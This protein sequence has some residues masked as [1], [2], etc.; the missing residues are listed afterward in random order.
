MSVIALINHEPAGEDEEGDPLRTPWLRVTAPIVVLLAVFA[1]L[2][3]TGAPPAQAEGGTQATA[4]FPVANVTPGPQELAHADHSP[5]AVARGGQL[6]RES[7]AACHG[8]DAKGVVNLGNQLA[9]S[10]FVNGKTDAELLEVVRK[11]RDLSDPANTTHLVM[12]PS[13]GRPDL[14]DQDLLS[15]I[16]FIRAQP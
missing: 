12:P 15:I 16:A 8:I 4:A 2:F 10:D 3:I 7:C 1:V 5:A 13:G 6:F 11:G 9:G 14:S